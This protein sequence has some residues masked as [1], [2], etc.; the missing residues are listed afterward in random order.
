M[1][2]KNGFTCCGLPLHPRILLPDGRVFLKDASD[3]ATLLDQCFCSAL[4]QAIRT[5]QSPKNPSY[6]PQPV[7]WFHLNLNPQAKDDVVAVVMPILP[8]SHRRGSYVELIP[9]LRPWALNQLLNLK[10]IVAVPWPDID[11]LYLSDGCFNERQ[12]K[13]IL[14]TNPENKC[15][16]LN[17][18]KARGIQVI[19]F[20][21]GVQHL[22]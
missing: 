2:D 4:W 12:G 15:I 18:Y 21:S 19:L 11:P 22:E 14:M 6:R 3:F 13:R 16:D 10:C 17:I 1:P 7:S 20:K 9:G 5:A 8:D